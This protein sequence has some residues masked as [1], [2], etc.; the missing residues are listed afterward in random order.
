MGHTSSQKYHDRVIHVNMGKLSSKLDNLLKRLG[1]TQK[2]ADSQ[3]RW[4]V[5]NTVLILRRH[6][7][8]ISKLVKAMVEGRSVGLCIGTI[9]DCI[10][11]VD[12]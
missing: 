7:G 12:I 9:E 8:V 6:R 2:K 1:F 4:A 10:D 11:D 5:L 3:V